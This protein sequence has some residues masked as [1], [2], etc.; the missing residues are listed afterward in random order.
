MKNSGGCTECGCT[1]D[2]WRSTRLRQVL[3][4]YNYATRNHTGFEVMTP[5]GGAFFGALVQKQFRG[6]MVKIHKYVCP[7]G[8][9]VLWCFSLNPHCRPRYPPLLWCDKGK[10]RL[11]SPAACQAV[12]RVLSSCRSAPPPPLKLRSHTPHMVVSPLGDLGM[13][14]VGA[15]VNG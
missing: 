9:L 12:P 15:D 7:Q 11:S 4:R 2:T 14:H 6:F 1:R 13:Y 8:A 10:L 5:F 3:P